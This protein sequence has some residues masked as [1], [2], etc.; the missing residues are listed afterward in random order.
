MLAGALQILSVNL[1]GKIPPATNV[2]TSRPAMSVSEKA[3]EKIKKEKEIKKRRKQC[4][5]QLRRHE[6]RICPTTG[7]RRIY[8]CADNEATY[9]LYIDCM[10]SMFSDTGKKIKICTLPDIYM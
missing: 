6:E 8:P 4:T 7:Y 5:K 1:M 2:W 10:P 9:Q 3:A